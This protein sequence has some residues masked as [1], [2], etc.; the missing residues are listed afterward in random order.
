MLGYSEFV[1]ETTKQG[2]E[3]LAENA[4]IQADGHGLGK[5]KTRLRLKRR[6]FPSN[7]PWQP[8]YLFRR[9]EGRP[10]VLRPTFS[11]GLPLTGSVGTFQLKYR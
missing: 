8:R 10:E 7:L 4:G 3:Q 11:S 2:N 9:S 5:V 1:Q 6:V